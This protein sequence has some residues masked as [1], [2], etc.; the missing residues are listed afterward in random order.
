MKH[1]LTLII[2][3]LSLQI[4]VCQ[5]TIDITFN[6]AKPLWVHTMV[7]TTFVTV[8][9]QNYFTKY[10]SITPHSIAR[11]QND[12]YLLA[13]SSEKQSLD[14]YG[15]VLDKIDIHTGDM[16]WT[17][18][19]TSNNGGQKDF[20]RS[21]QI[22]D[23]NI[24]MVG[25]VEDTGRNYYAS[26]KKI[27]INTGKLIKYSKAS[28]ALQSFYTSYYTGFILES[29]SIFLNAYTKGYDVGT[30]ENPIY[31][32]G[33]NAEVYDSEMNLKNSFRHLFDFDTLGVFSIDQSNF[34]YRLNKNNLISLAYK[35]RYESW[36]NLGTKIMWTDISDPNNIKLKQIKDYTDIVPGTKEDFRLQ[37]LNVNNNTIQLSHYYP[38]FDILQN[39][40]YI[41]W[42]DS[43]GEI[44]TYIPIPKIGNHIYH[45]ANMVYAN[46][47]FAYFFMYPS[48]T[49][50][51]GFD[52]T[53][54]DQGQD[55]IKILS[56][57]TTNANDLEFGSQVFALF[58]DDYLIFG[59]LVKK[60]GQ[61]TKSRN[62]LHCFKA[63]DLGI[64]FEPVSSKDY[65]PITGIFKIFP[66]PTSNTLYLKLE[67]QLSQANVEI[68]DLNGKL[69]KKEVIKD[70][71]NQIDISILN[72][73]VYLVKVV[74]SKNEQIGKIE[75]LIKIN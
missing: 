15:F 14:D 61:Q 75:K 24:E 46:N 72:N 48:K 60:M 52:I 53:R 1:Y 45:Y 35:D 65:V 20:Y 19:N 3:I 12:I 59:G 62:M 67:D 8:P 13:S 41:L 70:N 34:T 71:Y 55:T 28:N 5:E 54:I 6:E 4:S 58:E 49:G 44:K 2:I 23:N 56:S 7:D 40:C 25:M 32:Y 16:I 29:D 73:G 11:N 42:L 31:N 18:H 36:D 39:T 10:T 68:F 21:L 38:N 74:N 57:V 37:S 9:G 30:L 43:L 47:D 22:S 26:Y 64:N 50:R 33:I 51:Y 66:N 17:H 27:D 63:S 69:V